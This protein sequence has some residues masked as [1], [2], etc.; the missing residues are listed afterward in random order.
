[1]S[2]QACAEML[3]RGDP[4]RFLADM[5]VRPADR[6]VLFA[7]HAFNLEV[8]RA[9]WVTQEPMIAEMRLQWWRDA[10]DEIGSGGV[11]RRHEVV[12]PLA[13]AIRERG[14]DTGLLDAVIETRRRDIAPEPFADLDAVL[15]YL[16]GTAGNLGWAAAT[17]L[18]APPGSEGAVRDAARAGGA[19]NLLQALPDL[20]AHGR[21]AFAPDRATEFVSGLA[22]A[23]LSALA[24]ARKADLRRA[25][26]A[27]RGYWQA[28]DM[29][30]HADSDP[31]GAQ[32]RAF[33]TSEF[34]RRGSLLIRSALGGW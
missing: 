20:A 22:R 27:L 10:L 18:G 26:P 25:A 29:L 19:A 2:L 17:G 3:K 9:P 4:D 13:L 7:L 32:D 5:T 8:A 14:I 21:P 12:E 1:M 24:R 16:D 30:R 31:Q 15:D 23:G 11:V 33:A 6:A 28:A 34:R